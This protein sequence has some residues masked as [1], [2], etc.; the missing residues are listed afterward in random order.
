LW[1]TF[2]RPLPSPWRCLAAAPRPR[3][4]WT[5]A[6]PLDPRWQIADPL[7]LTREPGSGALHLLRGREELVS[8]L[9]PEDWDAL[10][11]LTRE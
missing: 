7:A 5:F 4:A 3:L 8:L 10:V 1:W 11:A 2:A 9:R 6:R